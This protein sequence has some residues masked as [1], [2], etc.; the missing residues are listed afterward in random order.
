MRTF[1]GANPV[2][3]LPVIIVSSGPFLIHFLSETR[4]EFTVAP[5]ETHENKKLFNS[6]PQRSLRNS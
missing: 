4:Y 6:A 2:W 3:R 5:P 1:D